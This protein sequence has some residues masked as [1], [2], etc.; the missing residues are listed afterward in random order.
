MSKLAI[1]RESTLGFCISFP[2]T[3]IVHLRSARL[4]GDILL[5]EFSPHRPEL[6]KFNGNELAERLMRW[7]SQLLE[8]LRRVQC[9]IELGA[10][11]WASM[12]RFSYQ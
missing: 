10:P 4:V 2:S 12:L 8:Q 3:I 9:D 11:F 6:D 5:G 7:E 1:I